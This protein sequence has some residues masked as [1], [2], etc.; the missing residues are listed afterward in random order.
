[1]EEGANDWRVVFVSEENLARAI[2]PGTIVISPSSDSW[3]D[4]GERILIEVIIQP[5]RDAEYSSERLTFRG[6]FWLS[7]KAEWQ[8]RHVVP[9]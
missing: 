8:I 1:M 7:R 6:F 3:N 2:E 4:F 9:A 5:M